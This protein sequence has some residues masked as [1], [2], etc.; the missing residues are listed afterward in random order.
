MNLISE[1]SEFYGYKFV[2]QRLFSQGLSCLQLLKPSAQAKIKT[3]SG[4]L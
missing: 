4:E 3:K 2:S 1:F